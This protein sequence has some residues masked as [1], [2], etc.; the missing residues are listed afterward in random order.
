MPIRIGVNAGSLEKDLLAK[1]GAPD[2]RGARRERAERGADPRG[3]GLLRHQDLGEALE[4]ARDD[5]ELP[6][7]RRGVRLPAAPRRHRGRPDA[8]GRREERGRDRDAPR[9][10]DRR[11]D[12]RLAHRRPRR[13]GQGR[14]DRSC[15]R[16]GCASAGSTWSRAPRAA[17]PRSNV[18]EL[19]QKVN[20]AIE[21]EKFTVPMRVAVMGCVVNGPG[22]AREADVG[23]ASGKGLGFIIAPGRGRREGPRGRARRRADRRGADRWRPR[24]SPPAKAP[25]ESSAS[26][27]P[28][29]GI[30]PM[31]GIRFAVAV[32]AIGAASPRRPAAARPAAVVARSP[33]RRAR[34]S[35][36][37]TCGT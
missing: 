23:I 11:H 27:T 14:H 26:G 8:D 13:G 16:S 19:T 30:G 2:A 10:G 33:A 24:R 5:R 35:R 22:E 25:T 36:P 15:S 3:R 1:Y 34:S 28:R 4:P 32:V 12:P 21:S 9:R 6:A 18:L 20:A 37:T 17:A 31:K 29:A 7:A